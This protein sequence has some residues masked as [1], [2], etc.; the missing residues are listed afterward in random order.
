[1]RLVSDEEFRNPQLAVLYDA[2]D[3]DRSD[4]AAYLALAEEL[5]ARRVLDIGCGTGTF[6]F[7]LAQL[8]HDVIGVDPAAASVQVA[9]AKS[10]AQQVRWLVGDMTSV[11]VGDRDLVTMTAN[12]AQLLVEPQA[13]AATLSACRAALVPGGYLVFE[14]RR[15]SARAWEGW[16]AQRDP[17]HDPC[18][19]DGDG[20]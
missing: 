17:T 4:L 18:G 3:S 14:S 5:R 20:A 10:G 8:G 2:L 16:T 15:P 6:A 19:G 9:R 1:M 11:Q 12:T 13:W 7:L